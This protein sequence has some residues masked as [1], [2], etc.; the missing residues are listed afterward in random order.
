[1]RLTG[2]DGYAG[3]AFAQPLAKSD[4]ELVVELLTQLRDALIARAGQVRIVHG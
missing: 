2:D 4:R 3:A 1:L